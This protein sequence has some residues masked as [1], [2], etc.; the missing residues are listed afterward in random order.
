[1]S[2][3]TA[4]LLQPPAEW[5]QRFDLV[6]ECITVQSLPDP[7]R[8][9]AIARIGRFLAPGGTLLVVAAARDEGEP[10][11]G[12]PWPLTRADLDAFAADGIRAVRVEDL[13][14]SGGDRRWRAEFRRP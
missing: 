6:V 14:L 2:Y 5:G 1:M 11:D 9:E 8:R 4:D 7:P 13:R 10:A 12:P 3:R